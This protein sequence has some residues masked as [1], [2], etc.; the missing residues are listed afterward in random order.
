MLKALT[1]NQREF[2]RKSFS[3]AFLTAILVEFSLIISG[4]LLFLY[5]KHKLGLDEESMRSI[6]ITLLVLGSTLA[7]YLFFYVIRVPLLDLT[8]NVQEELQRKLAKKEIKTHYPRFE[9][10]IPRKI[11]KPIN[12]YFL[13]FD[14]LVLEVDKEDFDSFNTGDIAII[15]LAFKSKQLLTITKRT[16]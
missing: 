14:E 12:R 16:S 9:H 1:D 8:N 4:W 10:Y 15:S 5:C 11:T 3:T 7:I 6:S 13:Y 2:L